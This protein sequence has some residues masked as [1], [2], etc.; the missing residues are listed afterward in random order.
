MTSVSFIPH[1]CCLLLLSWMPLIPASINL[2]GGWSDISDCQSFL[3]YPG[4]I[5]RAV[6]DWVRVVTAHLRCLPSRQSP[7]GKDPE[8]TDC[9]ER[10]FRSMRSTVPPVDPRGTLCVAQQWAISEHH[11]RSW[12]WRVAAPGWCFHWIP[13]STSW[14]RLKRSLSALRPP[15]ALHISFTLSQSDNM[16]SDLRVGLG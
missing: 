5:F 15:P 14:A 1:C 11:R 3:W 4:A 10:T 13:P 12:R 8:V 16:V 9:W 7:R 2:G 6:P